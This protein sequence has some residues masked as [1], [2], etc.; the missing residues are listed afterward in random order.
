MQRRRDVE[1]ERSAHELAP[2]LA[3]Q[4][5]LFG[6]DLNTSLL[7]DSDSSTDN[8]RL[9]QTSTASATRAYPHAIDQEVQRSSPAGTPDRSRSTTCSPIPPPK[10]R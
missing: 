9:F 3:G 5:F 10:Q 4:R 6:G 7:Y 1:I 2:V 8:A